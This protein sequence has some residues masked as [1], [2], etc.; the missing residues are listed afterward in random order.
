M[1]DQLRTKLKTLPSAPGVYFHKNSAGEIIY[2]G[3]AAVLKNRVRSYFQNTIK[4]P[5][6]TRLVSEIADTDWV[7]VD[8]EMDALFL[9]SEMVKRYMPR[10]N[11]DL[12]D[13]KN[14]VF[15]R[16]DQKSDVPSVTITRNPLDD[17]ASYFGPYLGKIV[18]ET[19]LRNLRR[20][21]PYYDKP[22]TGKRTLN[23]D[24]NLAPGIEIAP[25]PAAAKARYKSDLRKLI[26]YLKGNR[27]KLIT[28]IE[29]DMKAASRAENYELAATLRNQYL[30]LR[31][32][33]TKI[34]FSDQEFLDLSSD[35]AL[36]ALQKLLNL[37]TPPRRIDG[38][39]ISHQSGTN[40]VASQVTFINGVA[41]RRLYRKFKIRKEQNNDFENMREVIT[42][43]LN[44]LSDW[45]RP[46]LIL[47]DGG[48]PQLRAVA[49]LLIPTS[50]PFLG[51][52]EASETIVIPKF[53]QEVLKSYGADERS[54]VLRDFQPAK[55]ATYIPDGTDRFVSPLSGV[56]APDN[57]PETALP[58]A[59]CMRSPAEA[60]SRKA[61]LRSSAQPLTEA[62]SS[63][64]GLLEFAPQNLLEFTILPLPKN[65]HI[66][67]LLERIRDESHR[68]AVTYHTLLKRKSMLS[69]P[70]KPRP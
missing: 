60:G 11:I 55:T 44:H 30:G 58:A 50:I 46:D 33:K 14:A 54:S 8:S 52:A 66:V 48:E 31:G 63:K 39:D 6:T 17:G 9:E 61:E 68:F 27:T 67:K 45:G 15:V 19:A 25:D 7:V 38:F 42:R 62:G 53:N 20:V 22:Y 57:E 34:I 49:P 21:F 12:R 69:T 65:S 10:W 24:L 41:D 2:V 29:K 3:K 37:E 1:T 51:L 36:K 70:K 18:L 47:I 5:K 26:S 16:I 59:Q 40:V 23:T 35:A 13:D 56:G 28:D 32:L 4:D 43:R 64:K